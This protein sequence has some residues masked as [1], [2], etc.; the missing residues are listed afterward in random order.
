MSY[1]SYDNQCIYCGDYTRYTLC[2]DC[3]NRLRKSYD[4]SNENKYYY[5]EEKEYTKVKSISGRKEKIFYEIAI[6]I[7]DADK[8]VIFPQINLQS[9]I[10]VKNSNYRNDELFRNI[11]FGIFKRYNLEPILMVEVNDKRHYDNDLIKK[12]DESVKSILKHINLPLL[13]LTNEEVIQLDEERLGDIIRKAMNYA[14]NHV[15][16]EFETIDITTKNIDKL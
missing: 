10:E 9:I 4:E 1:Y 5:D 14:D 13:T 2:R 6:E 8:Y 12:R 16:T 3:W 11:D 7:L 15:I